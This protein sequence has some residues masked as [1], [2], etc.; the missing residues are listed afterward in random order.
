MFRLE[1]A[2]EERGRAKER[3][4]D[5]DVAI[6]RYRSRVCLS[7][8]RLAGRASSAKEANC[9]SKV[10]H[11]SL[12]II[13]TPYRKAK[14]VRSEIEHQALCKY[15]EKR[16]FA[17]TLCRGADKSRGL[18]YLRLAVSTSG[19]MYY[20]TSTPLGMHLDTESICKR[21]NSGTLLALDRLKFS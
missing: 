18:A 2:R 21:Y 10:S 12:H 16:Y 9:E 13:Y 3:R 14:Q 6:L 19:V 11:T 20:S 4:C 5:V 15:A 7:R 1:L 17:W 8:P